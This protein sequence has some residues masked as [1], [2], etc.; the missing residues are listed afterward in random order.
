MAWNLKIIPKGLLLSKFAKNTIIYNPSNV[1]NTNKN[2]LLSDNYQTYN[3]A[4]NTVN[5]SFQLGLF[6]DDP[7]NDKPLPTITSIG[8]IGLSND[9]SFKENVYLIPAP[10]SGSYNTNNNY[11]FDLST[12]N[13]STQSFPFSQ[14]IN[15]NSQTG[16]GTITLLNW[17]L[18]G[19]S[20]VKTIFFTINVVL[21]DG[22]T[23]TYPSN[24]GV[25]DQI[26]VLTSNN[27]APTQ[28]SLINKPYNNYVST[29]VYFQTEI[30]SNSGVSSNYDA[31][32]VSYFWDAL[33]LN[34][35]SNYVKNNSLNNNFQLFKTYSSSNLNLENFP[36]IYNSNINNGIGSTAIYNDYITQSAFSLSSINN[37]Y[38]F[39][40]FIN[41][42]SN[43]FQYTNPV[44]F[45]EINAISSNN[46]L[47]NI[48]FLRQQLITDLTFS[49]LTI[50]TSVDDSTWSTDSSYSPSATNITTVISNPNIVAQIMSSGT[51]ILLIEVIDMN[52]NVYQA[53][54]LFKPDQFKTIIVLNEVIF[55]SNNL[56]FNS[57]TNIYG[58]VRSFIKNSSSSTALENNQYGICQGTISA[59]TIPNEKIITNTSFPVVDT[60]NNF[61]NAQVLNTWFVLSNSP[62][63]G[64]INISGNTF[65]FF[66][67]NTTDSQNNLSA[68]EVQNNIP[69]FSEDATITVNFNFPST[70]SNPNTVFKGGYSFDSNLNYNQYTFTELLKTSGGVYLPQS[71]GSFEFISY[72]NWSGSNQFNLNV[73]DANSLSTCSLTTTNT[74][75]LFIFSKNNSS[76]LIQ[77]PEIIKSISNISTSATFSAWIG[78]NGYSTSFIISQYLIV[79]NK[80][81]SLVTINTGT[82]LNTISPG[83]PY[84]LNSIST[85][86]NNPTTL[87]ISPTTYSFT[88]SLNFIYDFGQLGS[89]INVGINVQITNPPDCPAV[90]PSLQY[91]VEVSSDFIN[92]VYLNSV[93]ASENFDPNSGNIILSFNTPN[94]TGDSN[95]YR[96]VRLI[97]YKGTA[98]FDPTQVYRYS[99]MNG[100]Q[101]PLNSYL[102]N[103]GKLI[104]GFTDTSAKNSSLGNLYNQP[105]YLRKFVSNSSKVTAL[106]LDFSDYN[107]SN[108]GPVYLTLVTQSGENRVE[109]ITNNFTA[110]LNYSATFSIK[111]QT[112]NGGL[113]LKPYI[114]IYGDNLN[115]FTLNLDDILIEPSDNTGMAFGYYPF[116]SLVGNGNFNLTT[117]ITTGTFNH[118]IDEV[119]YK[120]YF[121]INTQENIDY[122][123]NYGKNVLA[124]NTYLPN[125]VSWPQINTYFNAN[126]IQNFDYNNITY[127]VKAV[128]T[129]NIG[130]FG[131]QRVDGIFLSPCDYV[132]V[133]GQQDRTQNGVYQVQ[134]QQWLKINLIN[135]E[136]TI[137]VTQGTIFN[138]TLWMQD[139]ISS[140]WIP[141]T[142]VVPFLLNDSSLLY[143]GVSSVYK[144]P[145]YAMLA[146][147]VTTQQDI[148]TANQIKLKIVSSPNGYISNTDLA[149]Q[150]IGNIQNGQFNSLNSKSA[151]NN[152]VFLNFSISSSQIQSISTNVFPATFN[153]VVSMAGNYQPYA[154]N[155]SAF[156]LPQYGTEY[157]SFTNQ[158][159]NYILYSTYEVINIGLT[160][161]SLINTATYGIN[162]A[163]QKTLQSI[164][165]TD[166][167]IDNTAP[168]IGIVSKIADNVKSITLGISTVQDTG[169]GLLLARVVQKNP[170]NEVIYSNWVGFNTFSYNGVSSIIAYPSFV[171]DIN[172]IATGEPLSGYYKYFIQVSD[173]VGNISQSNIIENL[174]YESAIINTVGPQATANFISGTYANIAFTTSSTLI[175][176]FFSSGSLS[177]IKSFRYRILPSSNFSNWI[178]YSPTATIYLPSG[179]QDGTITVQFQ[180]KDFGNNVLYSNTTTNQN[181]YNYSWNI[182]SKLITNV[183]FTVV[184][185]TTYNGSPV[186]LI[187]AS[188]GS[189]QLYIWNGSTLLQLQYAGFGQAKAVTA[190]LAIGS[191]VII[192]TDIGQILLYQ[193]GVVTGP[194]ANLNIGGISLPI[195]KFAVNQYPTETYASVYATTLNIPRI[196]RTP[197][198]NLKNLSWQLVSTPPVSLQSININ[199]SGLW[200]G[201]QI[202]YNISSSYVPAIL[203]PNLNYG[204]TSI[205]VNNKGSKY[206]GQAALSLNGPISG[207][208]L[209]P[210]MQGY[211]SQL[212][213]LSFGTG[214]TQ[215]VNIA[216]DP[217]PSGANAI[218]ATGY[219]I[220]NSANQV[221]AIGISSPGYGYTTNPKVSLIGVNGFGTGAV[222]SSQ[223]TYD[224]IYGVSVVSPG[225]ATTT[226]I[227]ISINGPGYGA[228][229]TPDFQ[230]SVN[231]LNIINPGFGLITAPQISINGLT[232][233]AT[234]TIYNGSINSTKI[235][236]VGITFY[237]NVTPSVQA[238]NGYASSFTGI[239]NTSSVSF[240]SS[241]ITYAGSILTSITIV[242]GST[243]IATIPYI[244]FNSAIYPPELEYIFSDDPTLVYSS[245]SIYDIKS[246]DNRLFFTSNTSGII[247]LD[248]KNNLFHATKLKLNNNSQIEQSLTPQ[249]LAYDSINN[250]LLFSVKEEPFIGTLRKQTLSKIFNSSIDNI[251][252][253]K[254]VN[255]DILNDWQLVKN[256]NANGIATA[257]YGD[258]TNSSLLIQNYNGQVFYQSTKNNIWFNR[259]LTNSSYYLNITFSANYG[260]QGIE[261]ITFNSAFYLTFT[262]TTNN[263]QIAFGSPFYQTIFIP[264]SSSYNISIIKSNNSISIYNNTDVIFSQS[265][266]FNTISANPI[267]KFGYIFEPVQQIINNQIQNV[268]TLPNIITPS[269]FIWY[270]IKF[271]FN[272]ND[273]DTNINTYTLSLPYIIPNASSVR[274][275][276]NLNGNIF[277][278]TK[279]I[280]DIRSTTNESDLGSKVYQFINNSWNDVTGNFEVYSP[281]L[282]TSYIVSSPNDIGMI[283]SGYF[284]TGL[285]KPITSRNKNSSIISL[286][287]STNSFYEESNATLII[288]YPYNPNPAGTTINVSSNNNIFPS[289]LSV[290]FAQTDVV[291]TINV[292]LGSTSVNTLVT[293]TATDGASFSTT[294]INVLPIGIYT[295]K[296]NVSS[297]VG[298]S[299][300]LVNALVTLQSKPITNRTINVF[301]SLSTIL[302]VPS[303]TITILG[304]NIS[305]TI[306][307]TMGTAV[308]QSTNINITASY[309]NS[310]S[311]ANL[312][313]SPFILSIGLNT[314]SFVANQ[315]YGPLI[316]SATVQTQPFGNLNVYFNS[317]FSTIFSVPSNLIISPG[318]SSTNYTLSYA[319]FVTSSINASITGI[320]TGSIATAF[321]TAN[322]FVISLATSNYSQP[323]LGLQTSTITFTLNTSPA[324]NLIVYNVIKNPTGVSLVYP[325]FSTVLAG[326]STTSFSL[327]TTLQTV[328][329]LAITVQGAPLGWNTSPIPGLALTSDIWRIVN[330]SV[331]P[332]SLVGGGA[333]SIGIAQS[334]IIN[335]ILN[336]S[337]VGL[338]TT[339][340][341]SVN[342]TFISLGSS[343]L[344]YNGSA[345]STGFATGLTTSLVSSFTVTATG[346]NGLTSTFSG[347]TLSPFLISSFIPN[348]IWSGGYSTTY[349]VGGIG[350]T[351]QGLITLNAYPLGSAQ[352]LSFTGFDTHPFIYNQSTIGQNYGL[353]TVY[354]GSNNTSVNFGF[355][356]VSISIAT[357]ITAK[358]ISSSI[359]L[360]TTTFYVNPIPNYSMMFNPIFA[361]KPSII[362]ANI[363]SPLPVAVGIS[364]TINNGQSFVFNVLPSQT[365]V[366][367]VFSYN[368]ISFDTS[369][370]ANTNLYGIAQTYYIQGYSSSAGPFAM[371]YNLYGELSNRYPTTGTIGSYS[372]VFMGLSNVVK[373]ASGNHHNL[374][375]D[376]T[377]NVWG[378]GDNSYGQL[379]YQNPTGLTATSAF[380]RI[381]FIYPGRDIFA[382]NNTSYVI[383]ADNTLYAFGSNNFYALGSTNISGVSTN[384]PTV[385]CGS[386][387]LF[388][389]YNDRGTIVVYNNST[390][391]Q[392]VYEFGQYS[393]G[394]GTTLKTISQITYQGLTRNINNLIIYAVDTGPT[395]TVASATWNDISLG[396]TSSGIIAWGGNAYNQIG[397]ASTVGIT[398]TPNVL[399]KYTLTGSSP[400]ELSN[401][402]FADY[403]FSMIVGVGNSQYLIGQGNSFNNN[404]LGLGVGTT[405]IATGQGFAVTSLIT[406]IAKDKQHYVWALGFGSAIVSG[407]AS[408]QQLNSISN[409]LNFY[410]GYLFA[411]NYIINTATG[412]ISS[413]AYSGFVGYLIW[414]NFA[415]NTGTLIMGGTTGYNRVIYSNATYPYAWAYSAFKYAI[416]P[417][418]YNNYAIDFANSNNFWSFVL[419]NNNTQGYTANGLYITI[420]APNYWADY[421]GNTNYP[422]IDATI[423]VDSSVWSGST[424]NYVWIF[425]LPQ[426]NVKSQF[427]YNQIYITYWVGTYTAP[428]YSISS[429]ISISLAA[430]D[431]VTTAIDATYIRGF[432]GATF[433]GSNWL[434]STTNLVVASYNPNISNPTGTIRL[435][436][437]PVTT[438]SNGNGPV[439]INSWTVDSIVTCMQS[440][441]E[442]VAPNK[443]YL[444]IATKSGKLY[445]YN[446]NGIDQYGNYT[447]SLPTL[448]T[449]V[450]LPSQYGYI[451]IINNYLSG[452]FIAA[453]SNNYLLLI[454]NSTLSI[455]ASIQTRAQISSIAFTANSQNAN[456]TG[457]SQTIY[458]TYSSTTTYYPPSTYI[459]APNTNYEI[460]L[461]YLNSAGSYQFLTYDGSQTGVAMTSIYSVSTNDT[462]TIVLDS[463]RPN[464]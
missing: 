296:T 429:P 350:A 347:L 170:A 318:T 177:G 218:Q 172:G 258:S 422:F 340:S 163:T 182:I 345:T 333:N 363:G 256:L 298:Y 73:Y 291:K 390:G 404:G 379:G 373:T 48:K 341:L 167:I 277:A 241:G 322:P 393:A 74:K 399:F 415:A 63:S 436:G 148:N 200:S 261:I 361:N 433:G 166:Y 449:S 196:F 275:L 452:S 5:I 70:I 219:G 295:V 348:P 257:T 94:N 423:T 153:M 106:A 380:Q 242:N 358:I 223:I 130:L 357:S 435:F 278:A 331:T 239:F 387:Q 22:T 195:S 213:L 228:V 29:P 199:N 260:T 66:N 203:T 230:Y 284:I 320:V 440:I 426:D 31:G 439:Y 135:V 224:S 397:L 39:E 120:T 217:P 33:V 454:S 445:A 190:L 385:I 282:S 71:N 307:M 87:I 44:V 425:A 306:P 150:W 447:T 155:N 351:V 356:T 289:N 395:H 113:K 111:R 342:N 85:L 128:S 122:T 168:T 294:S 408:I 343:K 129:T 50:I 7:K 19:S 353:A 211:V 118:G 334:I 338:N 368:T 100:S 251:I 117:N 67:N 367:S 86:S 175:T 121:S 438:L 191:Q 448:L 95:S 133:T 57:N 248:Y 229:L 252:S 378:I 416:Q 360:A 123:A 456:A 47:S 15:L 197:I 32:M 364:V 462:Y 273:F 317:A 105:T 463:S 193:D 427:V 116:V 441:M 142:I 6:N 10:F 349:T 41:N 99:N 293:L 276:K 365:G 82:G 313:A 374:A 354:V 303:N 205:I 412:S 287:V 330:L 157:R 280:Y 382:Q 446:G 414:D 292:G 17:I 2:Q 149:T 264:I 145:G 457:K 139:L 207:A 14:A 424:Q 208:V 413:S 432:K 300:T 137:L 140:E 428:S 272:I 180:F 13:L 323:I 131:N 102:N 297:F 161:G 90:L 136:N 403:N 316:L 388:S 37:I 301:S 254:P 220:T 69:T 458:V 418:Q 376:Y 221:Y 324:Q 371:G 42:L 402:I 119:N 93:V 389:A 60:T 444:F 9:P 329:G 214:Y 11:F 246:F 16:N 158:N 250:R 59:G 437:T 152:T 366:S 21:S 383:T 335:P 401:L 411:N 281:N 164:Y 24:L 434:S 266:F 45:L 103:T 244:G 346:P 97:F 459:L 370:T 20:S 235:T 179:I 181:F 461:N 314:S 51:F 362:M 92:W 327:S 165:S 420:V 375:L 460:G 189:A 417:I 53:K 255:F 38:F 392:S 146:V 138:D 192:G 312:I 431:Y 88:N 253:F 34:S 65:S 202:Y 237:N 443:I 75:N 23:A 305:T 108:N 209:N 315:F 110:G 134:N 337:N 114:T 68:I 160:S 421:N 55:A 1:Q 267:I 400:I 84:V 279:S 232:T 304:G 174:Y 216:I 184:E 54:L 396:I 332:G 326:S 178:D 222:V 101:I 407:G 3:Q 198:N 369:L 127:T 243:G 409:T 344:Y 36:I 406:K 112:V 104:L 62:T 247:E 144:Y 290:Y 233:L 156:N 236:G 321:S 201:N 381:Q 91:S 132:L 288:V 30:A 159:I 28:P 96:F 61:Y 25:Y 18:S 372:K 154:T 43:N 386:V 12:L 286:A 143:T 27:S 308:N 183:L 453:T 4:N 339:V 194:Y 352:T 98:T 249:S 336:Y 262:V 359:G 384:I 227:S 78:T 328:A 377:G 80:G 151:S 171:P 245:G 319:G 162:E 226:A 147:G 81:N 283:G 299:S 169:S 265:N 442:P 215:G 188:S 410:S 125:Q 311:T 8:Y 238:I 58:E 259:C 115:L 231:S 302:N 40:V 285:I 398:T 212:Y 173:S 268:F 76:E 185:T 210:I 126:I 263:L 79:K 186:L 234:A 430:N 141:N 52:N 391:I 35:N 309:Q 325:S 419:R 109:T 269:S 204:I 89:I 464:G 455:L 451:T 107:S 270:G 274:V 72:L 394:I 64:T 124:Q 46:S 83:Q 26:T 176:Q 187:G 225:F 271:S 77:P 310:I 450:T 49:N 355:S 206:S 405:T 240:S 56:V